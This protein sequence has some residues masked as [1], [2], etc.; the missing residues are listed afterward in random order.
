MKRL[1]R[2]AGC[3]AGMILI[4]ATLGANPVVAA[5]PTVQKVPAGAVKVPMVVAGSLGAPSLPDATPTIGPLNEI[6]GTCGDVY[7]WIYNM[8]GGEAEV[9][10]GAD[11]S[12]GPIYEVSYEVD[13]KNFTNNNSDYQDNPAEPVIPPRTSWVSVWFP[14]VGAGETE[15]WMPLFFAYVYTPGGPTICVGKVPTEW[16]YITL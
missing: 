5:G 2:L 11:S 16:T 8:G 10:F 7:I 12:I 4:T 9:V 6:G 15:A 14:W 13:V 1:R 3:L